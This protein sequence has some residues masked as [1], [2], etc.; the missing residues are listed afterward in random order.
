MSESK[1]SSIMNTLKEALRPGDSRRLPEAE[2]GIVE[3][4]KPGRRDYEE[5]EEHRAT[6]GG[7]G[8]G[9]VMD[10]LKKA[11]GR[12]GSGSG[13][14]DSYR[15]AAGVTSGAFGSSSTSSSS[16]SS[17][18]M[19]HTGTVANPGHVS[20]AL[21]SGSGYRAG[22]GGTKQSGLGSRTAA[23]YSFDDFPSKGSP[24]GAFGRGSELGD[25]AVPRVSTFDS[26]GSIG[27]QFTVS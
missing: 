8:G 17:S 6:G 19:S 24:G 21:E 14:G 23:N 2:D 10:T 22:P 12:R 26:Q 20:S 5:R 25:R 18:D 1:T 3:A 13:G 7:G 16:S 11:L 4:M 15:N 9:G 27:H